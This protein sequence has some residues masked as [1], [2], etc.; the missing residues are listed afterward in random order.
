MTEKADPARTTGLICLFYAAI[1][2]AALLLSG[3]TP[4]P[5]PWEVTGPS[6]WPW[7]LLVLLGVAVGVVTAWAALA[8]ERRIP[9]A[10]RLGDRVRALFGELTLG[11]AAAIALSSG[12][13]EEVV[14]RGLVL[15][16]ASYLTQ[17]VVLGLL[18]SS[19]LFG[20]VH[21][22]P[23]REGVYWSVVA[24]L[25]GLLFGGLLLLTS[26]LLPPMAAHATHNAVALARQRARPASPS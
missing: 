1:G 4:I 20:M 5:W 14:F 23:G 22:A 9:V 7:Y 16:A 8:L 3:L 11:Q 18:L 2:A 26:S 13:V 24:G 6:V 21:R 10:K 12:V 17:S 25:L 19:V 15:M